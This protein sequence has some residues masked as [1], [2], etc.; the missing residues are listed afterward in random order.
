MRGINV[1]YRGRRAI[2]MDALRKAF[3]DW[4]Y[5]N[6]KTL[7]AS[8][9][10]VFE[11]QETDPKSL[12]AKI[13][14]GLQKVFGMEI[15][16]ILRSAKEISALVKASPF[17]GVKA[18]PE[19]QLYITFLSERSK[20]KLKIPYKSPAGDF[21]ILDVTKGHIASV[22]DLSR[23]GTVGAMS[24]LDKEFEATMTTRNWNTVLKVAK[25]MEIE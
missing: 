2:K 17:K 22:L 5:E 12:R 19:T 3:E 20:S 14:G 23:G 7:L 25:A 10:V 13:E 1:G 16:V 6:V 18:K 11:T 8:G 24:V 15:S 21:K 4:G 9:N